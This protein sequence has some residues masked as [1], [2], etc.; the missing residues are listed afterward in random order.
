MWSLGDKMKILGG[1]KKDIK[2]CIIAIIISLILG[3]FVI[4]NTNIYL[5]NMVSKSLVDIAKIGAKNIENNIDWNFE[6]LDLLSR[7]E[8][9]YSDKY[10]IE[11][12]LEYLNKSNK[13]DKYVEIAYITTDGT[14]YAASGRKFDVSS[15]KFFLKAKEGKKTAEMMELKF[16]PDYPAIA[17]TL[18]V[19]YNNSIKSFVSLIYSTEG[20]CEIIENIKF[21]NQGYG[22]VI[23][24]DGV[25]LA[26]IDRSLVKNKVRSIADANHDSSFK[27]LAEIETRMLQGGTGSGSYIYKGQKK[28]MG[29]T[30]IENVSWSF[31][32]TSLVKDAFDDA[33]P[34]V[35]IVTSVVGTFILCLILI[36]IYFIALNKKSKREEK[37]LRNAV[38]TA[39]I[40]I[41]SFADDGIILEFNV[42]AAK[43]LGYDPQ[44]I[45]NTVRVYDLVSSKDQIKLKDELEEHKK[46]LAKKNFELSMITA[47]GRTEYV[48]FNLSI[49]D[50]D[51]AAPVYEL[52]GICITDRVMS[53]RQLMEKHEELTAVYKQ[54]AA[55]EEELKDQ[56]QKLIK[57]KMLLQEKDDR[58]NLVVEA[59]NIGIWD[60]DVRRDKYFYSHK[61]YDIFEV[62][63][64]KIL[65]N[66]R[67]YRLNAILEEDR[68]IVEKAYNDCMDRVIP[69][70]EC[71][72]RV[73]TPNGKI[74]WIYEVGKAQFDIFGN[75][76]R[77]AGAH[78]DITIKK[79]SED[80]I[81]RLAYYDILTGLPNR[82]K[83]TEKFYEIA[84]VPERKIAIM[85]IDID[86]FK[87]VN[88]SYGHEVGDKLL[89]EVAERLQSLNID[90]SYIARMAGDDFA[91]M[92]WDYED[93]IR[94][95]EIITDLLN[96]IDGMADI[97]NYS[98]V[99]ETNIGVAIY[100]K[101]GNSFDIIYKNADTAK[102]QADE[103]RMKYAFY[104]Q[105]MNDAVLER[106]NLQNSLRT[107]LD[108]NEFVLYYQPQY[109]AADKKIMGFEALVRWN[110]ESMGL[111]S[112][113]K[114]IPVA[115][116]TRL[117]VR[118]G[119]WIL[120]EA[121]KF[122]K[123][124]HR[125]GHTDLIMSVNISN[126]QFIQKDFSEFVINL[127]KKYDL[128][129]KSLEL[130]ITESVMM[131]SMDN[132]INNINRIR[133]SGIRIALDDF[134]TGYSSL[135]YLTKI[136][137]NTLKIDKTF[138][139]DVVLKTERSLLV[140]A[141]VNIAHGL[142]LSIVAEGV[143][144]EDQYVYL[145]KHKCERI[146]GYFFSKPLPEDK[147]MD[148]ITNH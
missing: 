137:I 148:L 128:P 13:P 124:V 90:N 39:N 81:H 72:Y 37:T 50:S 4:V 36:N 135:N 133:E 92:V 63:K 32:A 54:L 145:M 115:E 60:W 67:T 93:E 111:V 87:L 51:S 143:E 44:K 132:V 38:E 55:S 74:K 80:R 26:H 35:I 16:Y 98:I 123:K 88:D 34:I 95:T 142:G 117:I 30:G 15:E 114:F 121:I 57:Q 130:E 64:E 101:D 17:F 78:S 11:D 70:Y 94:L 77:M 131:G 41:I 62:E 46:G 147:V 82:S 31:A 96:C 86:S 84:K 105:D 79:E 71:E 40:I 144:T 49:S 25:T 91:V 146:Q 33:S 9:I 69:Y 14:M 138:I 125:L 122:I 66:E 110:S 20:L 10:S 104:N 113:V 100:P 116:E 61:W 139:D 6:K 59:S 129:P 126:I 76:V 18:P 112:P 103:K 56:L 28:I 99:I 68:E 109:R 52:M 141:I 8:I 45:I 2:N 29:F 89:V 65:G 19:Y 27:K 106:L 47:D 140:E 83:L 58:H 48:L 22:Y 53:E 1:S 134:G 107:A 5:N 73:L 85:I 97:E 118:L 136:P 42:N 21:G 108:K 12:K 119:E 24:S 75:L 3:S 120:E 43:I 23:G 102:L 127:I 7:S